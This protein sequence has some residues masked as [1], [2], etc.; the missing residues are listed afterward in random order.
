MTY[1][2]LLFLGWRRRTISLDRSP[3]VASPRRG[4]VGLWSS[5]EE[6]SNEWCLWAAN[7]S[8]EEAK[9]VSRLSALVPCY[10]VQQ[11]VLQWSAS[12]WTAFCDWQKKEC[13]F[14]EVKTQKADLYRKR[15]QDFILNDWMLM[16]ITSYYTK[17]LASCPE[18]CPKIYLNKLDN[19]FTQMGS[20]IYIRLLF[21][22]VTLHGKTN[23]TFSFID[24]YWYNSKILCVKLGS[25]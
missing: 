20:A 3:L 13:W 17:C 18:S 23:F 4:E 22:M 5:D 1:F 24:I 2:F 6:V 10:E 25:I 16:E 8:Q 21:I 19:M 7:L 9:N 11:T 14:F 15:Y 12:K